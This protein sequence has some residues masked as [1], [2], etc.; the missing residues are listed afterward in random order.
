MGLAEVPL[1]LALL[2]LTAYVVLGGADFGAG[3]WYMLSPGERRRALREHTYHAMGPVWEANHVWLI[4]VL[5]VVWTAYPTRVRG[6][7]LDALRAAV[8][9]GARDHPPRRLLRA[10]QRRVRHARG[11]D[12]RRAVRRLLAADAVRARRGRGRDRL[13]PCAA[14]QR[15][16]RPD[17]LVAEPDLARWSGVLAVATS[18]Y[19]AAVWLTADAARAGR[20]DLGERV[21]PRALATGALAG[22]VAVGRAA[23]AARR[24]RADLRRADLGA[25]LVA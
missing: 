23:R 15:R 14:G 16:R 8:R 24:R 1:L 3:L 10:A 25:G 6:D 19:L 11:P 4:F 22:A 21:P 9:G 7:L 13:R 20:A 18:A 12:A 2:G 17:R 5:V